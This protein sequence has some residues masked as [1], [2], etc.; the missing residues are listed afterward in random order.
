MYV[1]VAV[2]PEALNSGGRVPGA[3]SFVRLNRLIIID[4]PVFRQE[5]MFTCALAG[6]PESWMG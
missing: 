4:D 1:N 6:C 3:C 2:P 5:L